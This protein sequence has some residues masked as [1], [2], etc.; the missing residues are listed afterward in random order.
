MVGCGQRDAITTNIRAVKGTVQNV[1]SQ[2]FFRFD[3]GLCQVFGIGLADTDMIAVFY[4]HFGQAE[5]Q[6][7]DFVEVT[8]QE[9]HATRLVRNSHTI[10]QLRRCAKTIKNGFFVVVARDAFL[11]T[12]YAFPFV[13]A[14]IVNA[15]ENFIQDRLN[16]RSKICTTHWGSHC[17]SLLDC[18][19]WGFVSSF[20]QANG[21]VYISIS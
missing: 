17:L 3:Q 9:Q 13:C 5:S 2:R 16:Y 6:T 10:G 14:L 21:H 18:V 19:N 15:V 7:V 4:K 20:V 11:F 12:E 8:L 1:C